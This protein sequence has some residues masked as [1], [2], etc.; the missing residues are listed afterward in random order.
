MVKTNEDIGE[1]CIKK[2]NGILAVKNED[3]KIAWK[4]YHKKLLNRVCMG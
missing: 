2:D 1:Q 4:S 3:K